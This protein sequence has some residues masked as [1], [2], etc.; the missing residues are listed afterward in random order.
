[1]KNT[2]KVKFLSCSFLFF[3]FTGKIVCM[4][5]SRRGEILRKKWLEDSR[6]KPKGVYAL[7][8][9]C[10]EDRSRCADLKNAWVGLLRKQEELIGAATREINNALER[11]DA[12]AMEEVNECIRT[13]REY[14]GTPQRVKECQKKASRALD[15]LV[16]NRLKDLCEGEF[17]FASP[18]KGQDYFEQQGLCTN[19]WCRKGLLREM[20]G[21]SR[22]AIRDVVN[23]L[24]RASK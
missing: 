13:G 21:L 2:S 4:E 15:D 19:D 1:M 23:D 12:L 8:S 20:T 9:K 17:C 6:P 22:E 18:G 7:L 11:R 5:R 14:G 3:S 10:V 24:S 16:Q